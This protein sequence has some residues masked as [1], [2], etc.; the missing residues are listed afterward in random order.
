MLGR[1][2]LI[3]GKIIKTYL[4]EVGKNRICSCILYI[5]Y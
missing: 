2:I 3:Q 4:H 5:T 1:G